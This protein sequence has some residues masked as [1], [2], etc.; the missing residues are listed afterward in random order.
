MK[1]L[2]YVL[3]LTI[4]RAVSTEAKRHLKLFT[5]GPLSTTDS[6]KR[7]MMVDVGSRDEIGFLQVVRDVRQRLVVASQAT[8]ETHDAVLVQGAGTHAVESV[9]GSVIGK[10]DRVLI[11][12]NGSYG[13]RQKQVCRILN[14]PFDSIDYPDNQAVR[15]ED[16]VDRL[17]TDSSITHVSMIHLETTAGVINPLS[18]VCDA[19]SEFPHVH[20]ILDSMS[21]FGAYE[22]DLG[23]RHSA[24]KYLISSANKN[25]QGVPGF[26]FCVYERKALEALSGRRPRSLALDLYQQAKGLSDGGQFRFTAPTHAILAFQQA[27]MEWEAEGGWLGR[28]ER[29]KANYEAIKRGI[30]RLGLRFYVDEAC[31]GY[32]ISA[33]CEPSHP[34]WSSHLLYDYLFERGFVIYPGKTSENT[35]RIGNIGNIHPEDCAELV[36][37]IEMGIKHMGLQIPVQ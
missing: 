19:L 7:R 36:L 35:F 20:L 13:E 1:R 29:Y 6:V 17:R 23:G 16:L 14:L 33:I 22:V 8:P 34:K 26:S 15:A 31:R 28:S 4:H 21:A 2:R 30:E 9:L 24:C 37:N 11:L 5:P 12:N 27:I 18:P 10:S 25:M 32:I 3:P